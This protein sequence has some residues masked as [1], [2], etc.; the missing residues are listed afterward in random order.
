MRTIAG[1]KLLNPAVHGLLD[2]VL[3]AAFLLLPAVLGFSPGAATVSH[4]IGIAYAGVSLLTKYPL[5]LLKLIPFPVHGVLESIM[6]GAWIVLP[7]MLGFQDD[8]VARTF[9]M[10]AGVGLLLVAALTDYK[11]S[12]AHTA[13]RGRERRNSMLDRRQ[14]YLAVTRERRMGPSDRRVYSAA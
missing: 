5:G 8:S 12:G 4:I 7:W 3:A 9:F 11:A 13:F 10:I 1:M 14:R 6:A 2:Y